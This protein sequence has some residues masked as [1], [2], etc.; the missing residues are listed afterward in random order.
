MSLSGVKCL[1][2]THQIAGPW[3]SELLSDLGAEVIKI[4]NPKGGDTSRSYPFFGN[5]VFATENRGK[6]SVTINLKSDRGREIFTKLARQSDILVENFAPGLLDRLGLGYEDLNKANP[7]LIYCSISGYGKS[8]SMGNR[9]AWDAVVQAISGLMTLTGEPDR[10]PMRAGTSIVD[11]TAANYALNAI[12]L[13]LL[14]REKT[15]KGRFVDISLFDSAISLVN[16]W[17][18]YSSITGK[19]PVRMGNEWPAFAPYQVFKARNGEHLFIGASNEEFWK[20][21]CGVLKLE[22][23]AGDENFSTN[24]RRVHNMKKLSSIIDEVT[25]SWDRDELVERL[26]EK[27]IPN[28]PVNSVREVLDDPSLLNRKVL[29]ETSYESENF[30]VASSPLHV[31]GPTT[32]G[33]SP[34]KLGQHTNEILKELGY[35]TREIEEFHRDGIV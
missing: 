12:L 7:R 29:V 10:L 26:T 30:R 9:P 31:F 1:D 25:E 18:A 8:S 15:G 33:T 19:T 34:P 4:E 16:Y 35:E 24:D 2:V 28:A 5:S 27:G 6:K 3:T 21:L 11:L 17:I 22:S 23:L 20:E 32:T 14:E 13:S